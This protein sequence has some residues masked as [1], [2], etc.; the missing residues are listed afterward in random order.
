MYSYTDFSFRPLNECT[1]EHNLPRYI[2]VGRGHV[3]SDTDRT[4]AEVFARWIAAQG[5]PV[6]CTIKH[7]AAQRRIRG[8]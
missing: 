8:R 2:V 4:L 5:H 6:K 3:F 1:L 7:V